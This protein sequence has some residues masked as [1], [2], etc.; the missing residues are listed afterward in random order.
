VA[1]PLTTLT[2][3]GGLPPLAFQPVGLPFGL[4]FDAAT[5]TIS[6]TPTSSGSQNVTFTVH[7]SVTPFNQTGTKTYLLTV[8]AA[9]TINNDDTTNPLPGG[10]LTQPYNPT[11]SATLSA[12]GGTGPGTYSWSIT[13]GGSTPAP[14]LTLS[15]AGVIS[16]TPT[17]SGTFT[18]TYKV[19]DGNGN[20]TTKS[21]TISTVLQITNTSLPAGKESSSYGA[22]GGV[23]VTPV[24]LTATG[25]TP[26][27]SFS[28]T[29]TPDLTVVGLSIDAAGHI[30]G[31]PLPGTAGTAEYEFTVSDSA[32]GV[33]KK[34][35]SLT[36]AAP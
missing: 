28:T 8:N 22:V 34:K 6:G 12:S 19:Q 20:S 32:A 33:A 4:T 21:L 5:A 36:I 15:T 35:L 9:L 31:T 3:T 14:G 2:A 25:G 1:Y 16:G 24:T 29:T 13:G 27:Y 26:P 30:T 17:S 10:T 18:R 7:D 23:P 11:L